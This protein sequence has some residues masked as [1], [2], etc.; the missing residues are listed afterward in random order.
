M[1]SLF[2][3]Y[4]LH[5]VALDA[6]VLAKLPTDCSLF[7]Y[8]YNK[9]TYMG[10]HIYDHGVQKKY[11]F[12]HDQ[13]LPRWPMLPFHNNSFQ[14]EINSYFL[15]DKQD[16]AVER[17][18]AND[19]IMPQC[20]MRLCFT[21]SIGRSTFGWR[22][23]CT[24]PLLLPHFGCFVH[25]TR[26]PLRK[27]IN[28]NYLLCW[29]SPSHSSAHS[30]VLSP[31]PSIP[32]CPPVLSLCFSCSTFQEINVAVRPFIYL[33]CYRRREG[34]RKPQLPCH[35][36]GQ[37]AWTFSPG[38]TSWQWHVD[39]DGCVE[40]LAQQ[41]HFPYVSDCGTWCSVECELLKHSSNPI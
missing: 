40:Q 32:H 30:L 5:A 37:P 2:S 17:K 31:H 33:E 39:L 7:I 9:C 8:N 11:L 38:V 20:C 22:F 16:R 27:V 12:L 6:A 3:Y 35:K 4:M 28:H 34:H 10:V 15:S 18:V 25:W 26:C 29:Q 13:H 36:Y 41:C 23:S 14:T 24:S 19:L 1:L 21:W